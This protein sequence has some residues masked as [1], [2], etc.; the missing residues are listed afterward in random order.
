ML[1]IIE[2]HSIVDNSILVQLIISDFHLDSKEG[3]SWWSC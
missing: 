1:Q 3:V 2:V